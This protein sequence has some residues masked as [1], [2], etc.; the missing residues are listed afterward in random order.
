M[1]SCVRRFMFREIQK[2]KIAPSTIN[3]PTTPPEIPPATP[4]ENFAEAGADVVAVVV[5]IRVVEAC[6]VLEVFRVV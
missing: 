2:T 1:S 6:G 4:L 5:T 3:P